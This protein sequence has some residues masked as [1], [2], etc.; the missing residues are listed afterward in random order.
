MKTP[1]YKPI[2]LADHVGKPLVRR[3]GFEKVTGSATFA[4]EW[5]LENL[6]YAVPVCSR[7]ASGHFLSLDSRDAGAHAR[8]EEHCDSGQCSQIQTC[9]ATASESNFQTI[10]HSSLFPAAEKEIFFA[11]QFL[12]AVVAD[13]YENARDAALLI[14]VETKATPHVTDFRRAEAKERPKSL[15]GA[16]PV[17]EIGNAVEALQAS[18]VSIDVEYELEGKYH[19]PIEPHATIAHWSEKDGQPFLTVYE[20]TQS[21]A[22]G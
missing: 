11:G 15:M 18:Q 19:N 13:S 22:A 10:A 3:G 9:V 5:P 1:T 7:V 21:I 20:S 6:L 17:I 14:K 4:A 16:P 2:S 8:C 12:A